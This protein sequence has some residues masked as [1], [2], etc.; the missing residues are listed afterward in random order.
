MRR[1]EPDYLDNVGPETTWPD[2]VAALKLVIPALR[3][4][5]DV[6]V[7]ALYTQ[8]SQEEYCASWM[9][10]GSVQLDLFEDWLEDSP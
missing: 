1:P 9:N 7:D 5:S 4:L 2:D 3:G 6:E 10:L 8:W